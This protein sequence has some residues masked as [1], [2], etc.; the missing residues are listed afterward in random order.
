MIGST[1]DYTYRFRGLSTD[2]KPNLTARCNGSSFLE[3]DTGKQYI[4]DGQSCTWIV[5]KGSSGGGSGGDS[6]SAGKGIYITSDNEIEVD[7]AYVALKSELQDVEGSDVNGNIIID[8]TETK[9]YTLPE[10]YE[11]YLKEHAYQAPEIAELGLYDGDSEVLDEYE[12]GDEV[13]LNKI[14]HYE[15]NTANIAGKLK[16]EG[17]DI[18]ASDAGT[19]VSLKTTIRVSTTTTLTLSGTDTNGSIFS[20]DK[21]ITF[22]NHAYSIVSSESSAPVKGLTKESGL[23]DF[24][25]SGNDFAY[26]IGDYLYLYVKDAGRTVETSILDQWCEVDYEELG[27]VNIT[28]ANGVKA[29]YE[30]YRIGPFIAAGHAKYRV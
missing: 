11:E 16:F 18:S 2:A 5:W 20:K 1:N 26:G 8:G 3:M 24:A 23:D 19:K 4:F 25:E 29:D 10:A 6:Y 9:V 22:G 21:T 27:A 14:R 17:Q 28:Q 12:T 15:T 13:T 30:A 7:D